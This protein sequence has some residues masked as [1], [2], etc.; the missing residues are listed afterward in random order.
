MAGDLG[1][2][3]TYLIPFDFTNT[4][5]FY[6]GDVVIQVSE[7]GQTHMFYYSENSS[8]FVSPVLSLSIDASI[9]PDSKNLQVVITCNDIT[10]D[11]KT[12]AT[13]IRSPFAGGVINSS[14]IN[15]ILPLGKEA[16]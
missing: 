9:T 8:K 15:W 16:N 1:I 3:H 12:K 4:G 5:G 2:T 13:Y 10:S 11:T 14:V 6:G 7:Y